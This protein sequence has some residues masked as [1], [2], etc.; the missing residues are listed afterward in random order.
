MLSCCPE[1]HCLDFKHHQDGISYPYCPCIDKPP[2][3][4]KWRVT[5]KVHPDKYID[6]N[7]RK[8]LM[9]ICEFE[10][11]GDKL[12]Q[13]HLHVKDMFKMVHPV[14]RDIPDDFSELCKQAS[15]A[16][17]EYKRD[18]Q[19]E[20]FELIAKYYNIPEWIRRFF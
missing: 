18:T 15:E 2:Q 13:E 17:A 9:E 10:Y 16:L 8:R 11:E 1:G 19:N 12:S 6:S 7:G 5:G 4:Y 3:H 20:N 14:N